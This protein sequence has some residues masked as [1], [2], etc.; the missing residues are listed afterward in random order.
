MR[1]LINIIIALFCLQPMLAK[2]FLVS[3]GIANYP[4]VTNDL[5]ISDNDARTMARVFSSSENAVTYLLLNSKATRRNLVSA[6]HSTFDNAKADDTVILYF[7]GHGVPGALVCFDGLFTY[8]NMYKALNSC[9]ATKK[10][11]L[12][13]ACFSGKMRLDN[14]HQVQDNSQNVMF[15][16]SSRTGETAKE[17]RNSNSLFTMYLEQGLRGSA[18]TNRNRVITAREIYNYVHDRVVKYSKGK[19]HPVMWGQFDRNMPVIK[20]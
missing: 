14:Q 18:D 2:T 16:L 1:R 10:I 8:D 7:S 20:W 12:I 5:R 13:D 4:G 15:F 3:V 6:M 17:T 9:R 11:I 19:Q